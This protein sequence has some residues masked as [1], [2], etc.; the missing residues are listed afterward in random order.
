MKNF[1]ELIEQATEKLAKVVDTE[2]TYPVG[3]ISHARLQGASLPNELLLKALEAL[4]QYAHFSIRLEI[5][6]GSF[7]TELNSPDAN[8]VS[9]NKLD[10]ATQVL[11]EIRAR[12]EEAAK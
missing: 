10:I 1:S 4:E 12:L 7:S 5:G 2:N 9:K 6:G 3:A 11:A 8:T